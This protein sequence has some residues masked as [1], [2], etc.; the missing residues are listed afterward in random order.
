MTSIT[1]KT[2]DD[3]TFYFEANTQNDSVKGW[4]ITEYQTAIKEVTGMIPVRKWL[5]NLLY[6]D[7]QL[8]ITGDLKFFDEVP[9]NLYVIRGH[10]A[11]YIQLNTNYK[12][13]SYVAC[14]YSKRKPKYHLFD[15]YKK[16]YRWLQDRQL[17][18]E[19]RWKWHTEG[20]DRDKVVFSLNE[21]GDD[22]WYEVTN[23]HTGNVVRRRVDKEELRKRFVYEI[24]N[25]DVVRVYGRVPVKLLGMLTMLYK[26]GDV[27]V[28]PLMPVDNG[29]EVEF[30]V[31]YPV[32]RATGE[33]EIGSVN[34]YKDVRDIVEKTVMPDFSPFMGD[35]SF[36]FENED[37]KIACVSTD[38]LYVIDNGEPKEFF[39]VK[40]DAVMFVLRWLLRQEKR[41]IVTGRYLDKF[42]DNLDLQVNNNRIT[43]KFNEN[44]ILW[45]TVMDNEP[46]N[47]YS[48][49]ELL[50][51]C[52]G[53]GETSNIILEEVVW[54]R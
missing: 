24:C 28:E 7:K 54:K 10:F 25:G 4:I 13:I 46:V 21:M 48:M 17:K 37:D 30:I 3:Y 50:N 6:N 44:G 43:I 40:E 8:W 38:G 22:C 36:T 31:S 2:N 9:V 18:R 41:T 15:T 42:F 12:G 34:K 29:G 27:R 11:I 53:L 26:N 1:I 39:G 35:H 20:C 16:A 19:R 32:D 47:C 5:E 33:V 45:C 14:D 23:R 52:G 51:K 49:K